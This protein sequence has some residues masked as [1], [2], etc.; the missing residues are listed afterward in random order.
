MQNNILSSFLRSNKIDLANS[1]IE[2]TDSGLICYTDFEN[3][4]LKFKNNIE[5]EYEMNQFTYL[6]VRTLNKSELSYYELSVEQKRV[7]WV[8]PM[9]SLETGE[10]L[11]LVEEDKWGAIYSHFAIQSLVYND[12]LFEHA[13]FPELLDDKSFSLGNF[14]SEDMAVVILSKEA[15]SEIQPQ[16]IRIM[17]MQHGYLPIVRNQVNLNLFNYLDHSQPFETKRLRINKMADSVNEKHFSNLERLLMNSLMETNTFACFLTLYQ[18]L[19]HLSLQ[20]FNTCVEVL[21]VS[22]LSRNPWILKEKLVEVTNEKTRLKFLFDNFVKKAVDHSLK[23]ELETNCTSYLN[24]HKLLKEEKVNQHFI[25]SLYLVRNTIV[26]RQMEL[27]TQSQ[28]E[29]KAINNKLYLLCFYLLENVDVEEGKRKIKEK[30]DKE[31]T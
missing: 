11:P 26:H 19:E 23:E 29:L 4:E 31:D 25:D 1:S 21:K 5:T 8:F 15:I 7:G 18:I 17:L 10:N 27:T 13:N 14:Y 9:N 20:V 24:E 16:S 3:F 22:N 2:S 28:E 12:L 6:L 30:Y